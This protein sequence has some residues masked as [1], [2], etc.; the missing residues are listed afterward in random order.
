ML[1]DTVNGIFSKTTL[2][3][4]EESRGISIEKLKTV[5]G[6]HYVFSLLFM[7]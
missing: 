4:E 1:H 3:M 5:I 7:F 6:F 2:R